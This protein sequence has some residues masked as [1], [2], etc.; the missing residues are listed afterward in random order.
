[1]PAKHATSISVA[2]LTE[3]QAKAELK[4]LAPEIA[5]HDKRYY[6]QDAPT[7]TDA[8][9]DALRQR[10]HASLPGSSLIETVEA[11]LPTGGIESEEA[12]VASLARADAG[13]PFDLEHGPLLRISLLR[14]SPQRHAVLLNL[15]HIV[16]DGWS[17]DVLGQEW[18]ALY[19]ACAAGRSSPLTPLSGRTDVGGTR[20]RTPGSAR[21]RLRRWRHAGSRT[22]RGS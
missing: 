14:L 18:T 10:I 19:H 11:P 4:R 22:R 2:D 1:M 16:C 21:R 3:A 12:L 20:S 17:M 15:H 5:A 9:Y 7:I 6:Q 13:K 8:E